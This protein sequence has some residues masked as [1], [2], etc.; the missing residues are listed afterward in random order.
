MTHAHPFGDRQLQGDRPPSDGLLVARGAGYGALLGAAFGLFVAPV[1]ELVAFTDGR[2]DLSTIVLGVF[3]APVGMLYGLVAG[4]LAGAAVLLVPERRRRP[5][6]VRSVAAAAGAFV[7]IA[8]SWLLIDPSLA[9]GPNEN[10]RHVVE[11]A[12]AFYA[13]PGLSAALCGAVGG[14]RLVAPDRLA[15]D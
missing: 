8:I 4:F 15:D 10:R 9:V 12:V 1:T 13:Y 6:V 11:R 2:L 5:V 3:T 14:L 7:V